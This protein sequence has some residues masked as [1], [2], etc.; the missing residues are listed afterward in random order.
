MC[1]IKT[2]LFLIYFLYCYNIFGQQP[3][4]QTAEQQSRLQQKPAA[5]IKEELLTNKNRPFQQAPQLIPVTKRVTKASRPSF[6]ITAAYKKHIQSII[7][8]RPAFTGCPDT[9]I[10][11]LFNAK[12][13]QEIVYCSYA[14]MNGDVLIGGVSRDT[15]LGY[16]YFGHLLRVNSKGEILWAKQYNDINIATISVLF[17]K[18]LADGSIFISGDYLKAGVNGNNPF[19]TMMISKLRSTGDIIWSKTYQSVLSTCN[20][21]PVRITA[22]AEG[23]NN[24]ILF[25]ASLS[26]C[27]YPQF[28]VVGKL[29]SQGSLLWDKSIKQWNNFEYVEGIFFVAGKVVVAG[30]T[31]TED[32]KELDHFANT[33]PAIK[34]II[35]PHNIGK[36]RI[37]ECLHLYKNALT[38][39][40][41]SN[42]GNADGKN[43]LIIDNIGMLST[44]Y[45]YADVCYVGGG[46]GADGVHN[47]LEPAVY[48]KPVVFGPEYEKFDEAEGLLDAGGALSVDNALELDGTLGKLLRDDEKRK[49]AGEQARIFVNQ[50]AGATD[51]VIT[52]IQEKRLL[53]N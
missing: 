9:T 1:M 45:G 14:A 48:G 4:R 42:G 22:I 12:G 16:A 11:K 3:T 32:D 39:S 51:K 21:V 6:K 17:I 52:Y 10:R 13:L 44:L 34:F 27:P 8:Q 29:S 43:T 38:Y 33:N 49:H 36:D 19:P 7:S 15:S 31:W 40:A 35:A 41:L 5:I 23:I 26:N 30:S 37:D 47:V 25:G 18:E 53:T 2:L 46:F 24:E 50:Q 28:Q 20:Y